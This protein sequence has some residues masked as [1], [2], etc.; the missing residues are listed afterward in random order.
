MTEIKLLKNYDENNQKLRFIKDKYKLTYLK[1]SEITGYSLN[2][3]KKWLAN[4]DKLYY[5]NAPVQA[6]KLMEIWIKSQFN[7]EEK[8]L[9]LG[10]IVE[11]KEA[12]VWSIITNKGGVGKTTL[13]FNFALILANIYNK[14]VLAIDLD[15]QGHLS[16]SLVKVPSNVSLSTSGLLLEKEGTP[17]K[18][19]NNLDVI[20]TGKELRGFI[21]SIPPQDLLFK[22][23]E[24]MEN[25]K[26][27]YDYIICDGIPTDSVW[28][29]SILAATT[30]VVMPFTVDLY[31]SWGMQDVFDK[32]DLLIRR[33]V[34]SNLKVAAIVGNSITKPNSIFDSSII[35]ALKKAYPIELCPTLISRSVK[36]KES[37]NPAISMS[38]VEYEP[39]SNVAKEYLEVVNFII[40]A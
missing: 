14:K 18:Y 1:M 10:E 35:H 6:L 2:A 4:P 31:D 30:K 38:I 32:V 33:K 8:K 24:K 9:D 37:K 20:A 16:L 26:Y 25:L 5:T 34:T 19:N 13:S 17:F 29:D 36:V 12:E 22:L 11:N 15:P 3:V 7:Q 28:F 39:E 21:D 40:N 27:S 23:K